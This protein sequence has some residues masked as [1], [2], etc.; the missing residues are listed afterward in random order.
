MNGIEKLVYA[1]NSS[2]YI[3][4]TSPTSPLRPGF[5][6]YSTTTP[7][8]MD[9]IFAKLDQQTRAEN[10]NLTYELYMRRKHL[11]DEWRSNIRSRMISTDC[12]DAERDILRAAL[13]ACDS[14]E[15]KLN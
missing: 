15:E 10:A 1:K 14:R 3:Y 5:I 9:K 12:S 7:S 2:G 4:L 8:E 13:A 11:I 6:R